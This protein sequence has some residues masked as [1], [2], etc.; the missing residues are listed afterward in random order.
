MKTHTVL[1]SG[2]N[3]TTIDVECTISNG[4]PSIIIIGF[5]NKAVDEAKERIRGAFKASGL[6]LPKKRITI[7]LAPADLPKHATSLDLAIATSILATSQIVPPSPVK[8]MFIGELGLDGSVRAVRGIVGKLLAGKKAGFSTFF[9]PAGNITQASLI[10]DVRLYPLSSLSE[11]YAHLTDTQ[12]LTAYNRSDPKHQDYS[13]TIAEYDFDISEVIGQEQA[14]RALEIAAAG[15]H[16]ILLSGPPGTGKS[17]LAKSLITVLPPMTNQEILEVT[18][19][20]SLSNSEY[21]RLLTQRPFRSPHHS[22]SDT[23]IVGGGKNPKPGEISLSHRGVLML[24][25]FPEF[26][27]AT[28]EALRQPLEDNVITIARAKDTLEFPADFILVATANPCPCGNYGT[29][30]ICDCMPSQIL[31]YQRKLSGPIIDRIDLHVSVDGVRHQD[32][33]G[34]NKSSE[35]SEQIQ[36]RVV[37]AR[38]KQLE[39]F[40]K[41]QTNSSMNNRA[42][43]TQAL[44]ETSA[45]DLLDQAAEK[46]DISAR[47]YMRTIKVAR[48]I[49]DLENSETIQTKHISEALQ[50]RPQTTLQA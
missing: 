17:M 49:A 13:T 25:E 10:E 3:G 30:K 34:S 4:L 11:L 29:S 5:A 37:S 39:R 32:L 45:K 12:P 24:D 44:L 22:S 38:K 43:K 40:K 21:D 26:S 1:E 14:K 48:T 19:L 2:F 8:A 18:H 31:R 20:H 35:T 16:N 47:G 23:A 36:K 28:I 27:R 9:I 41:P 46:L 6:I 33:L 15:G 7:N 42:I 50:Y